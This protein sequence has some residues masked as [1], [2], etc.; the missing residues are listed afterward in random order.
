MIDLARTSFPVVADLLRRHPKV[1]AVEIGA[2]PKIQ[3][4][5]S[6]WNREVLFGD[7][8]AEL[9][10]LVE[11]MDNN[12][13]VCADR[14]SIPTPVGVLAAIA[15]GPLAIAG[16]LTEP[17]TLLASQDDDP[18]AIDALLA[19]D[20]WTE[21]LVFSA[22]AQPLQGVIAATAIAAI[23]T[24]ERLQDIDDLYE[25]RFGRSFFVHRD[26]DSRWDIDL[27]KGKQ[28]AVYRLRIAA[29]EPQSLLTIQVMADANGKCGDGALVHAMNVMAGF[30][31]SL[32]LEV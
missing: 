7:F 27:V 2:G 26:E 8:S 19:R 23:R 18:E 13:L 24:P 10:G 25:E 32:G 12:P 16:L 29:D 31:E 22:E 6:E 3:F 11:L 1:V 20:G 28:G 17:P 30:E 5:Q 21:G 14:V 9:F 15:L 4:V